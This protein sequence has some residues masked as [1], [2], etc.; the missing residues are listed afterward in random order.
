V[1]TKGRGREPNQ[2]RT[3]NDRLKLELRDLAIRM[4]VLLQE[5]RRLCRVHEHDT[6]SASADKA[7][8]RIELY[9]DFILAITTTEA[10]GPWVVKLS[11]PGSAKP[12]HLEAAWSDD[13]GGYRLTNVPIGLAA[14]A[15]A[16]DASLANRE[17]SNTESF[18]WTAMPAE[19]NGIIEP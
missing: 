6:L 8:H 5:A 18:S 12:V 3:A 11:L 15:R 10:P 17:S 2:D 4:N 1:S 7:L 14:V 13:L 16:I 9:T 19:L